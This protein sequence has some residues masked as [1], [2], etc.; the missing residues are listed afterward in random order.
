MD[1]GGIKPLAERQRC[2][3]GGSA[4]PPERGSL[5]E[6]F[7]FDTPASMVETR[8]HQQHSTRNAH[9]SHTRIPGRRAQM[10]TGEAGAS[11]S[12]T[13]RQQTEQQHHY[14]IIRFPSRE[15]YLTWPTAV[16]GHVLIGKVTY[17]FFPQGR[18]AKRVAVTIAANNS[19]YSQPRAYA[20]DD[21]CQAIICTEY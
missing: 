10:R 3:D 18:K 7:S 12:R 13:N 16:V 14:S 20:L 9:A 5:P 6:H 2:A 21:R 4:Y 17:I 11:A 15:A 19:G 1:T 8:A